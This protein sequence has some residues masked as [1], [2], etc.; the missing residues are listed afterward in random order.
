MIKHDL[1]KD[2]VKDIELLV[3]SD[4]EGVYSNKNDDFF[5][6][7]PG[8]GLDSTEFVINHK[9]RTVTALLKYEGEVWASSTAKCAPD[10]EFIEEI[11]K[12]IATYRIFGKP[13]PSKYT[14]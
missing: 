6:Y 2:A 14:E 11:G 13:V 5:N 10:D 9:K 1:I 4:H 7:V 8:R 3:S 12:V